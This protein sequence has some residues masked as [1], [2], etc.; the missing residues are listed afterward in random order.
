MKREQS[1]PRIP[2][3]ST[4]YP[5]RYDLHHF[6]HRNT[7]STHGISEP[8]SPPQRFRNMSYEDVFRHHSG[9]SASPSNQF[10]ALPSP[11]QKECASSDRANVTSITTSPS[12]PQHQEAKMEVTYCHLIPYIQISLGTNGPLL[13]E[14]A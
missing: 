11:E 14:P 9:I 12:N 2:N 3:R 13:A 1:R 8:A 5:S 6:S 4:T 10:P 7:L